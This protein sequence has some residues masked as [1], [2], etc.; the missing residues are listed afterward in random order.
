MADQDLLDRPA[1]DAPAGRALPAN[2]EAEAAFLG[3]V[4]ID[5]RLM[6]ELAVPLRPEHFFEPVHQRF[7]HAIEKLLGVSRQRFDVAA[8]PLGVERVEGEAAFA[9]SR[10]SGHH[11]EAPSWEVDRDPLQVVLTSVDDAEDGI[12]HES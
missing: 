6:E 7:R 9:R 1:T 4:L 11:D 10:W 5:N 12:C 3:A 8:L 2:L